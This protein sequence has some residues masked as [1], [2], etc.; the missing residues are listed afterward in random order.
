MQFPII[1]AALVVL[2]GACVTM[3][4]PI[5]AALGRSVHSIITAAAISF[6]IGFL[7]LTLISVG[8]GQGRAF[9]RAGSAT[10]W[11]WSGG[12]LGAFFVWTMVSNMPR[13]G[14]FTAICALALGQILA[15]LI[16]DRTG[17]FGLPLREISLP[18][19]LAALMVGGGL[20]LS[21]F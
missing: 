10:W 11:M 17:A 13:L 21:R 16:I 8:T 4:A 19:I 7:I 9:L 15:A 20:I 12:A 14:A 2:A 18:R 3:Q 5:N 1:A 6:G